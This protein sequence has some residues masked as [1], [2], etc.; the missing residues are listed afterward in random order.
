[1]S[2]HFGMIYC[3]G[4][5]R[6]YRKHIRDLAA[7]GE[8]PVKIGK[9]DDIDGEPYPGGSVWRTRKDAQHWPET[10]GP[11][12]DPPRMPEAFSVF[13]VDADWERDTEPDSEH[14][15]HNLL[16]DSPLIDLDA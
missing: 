5:T 8:T 2:V 7:R 15:F 14:P 11:Q 6:G 10:L 1:M 13:G 9:R 4:H 3:I 16:K 12:W